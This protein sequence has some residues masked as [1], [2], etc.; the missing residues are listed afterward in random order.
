MVENCKNCKH[1]YYAYGCEPGCWYYDRGECSERN[2]NCF[3]PKVPLD[4]QPVVSLLADETEND[5][6]KE[7]SRLKKEVDYWKEACNK[8]QKKHEKE[9]AQLRAEN[10][11]L[12]QA[13]ED[14]FTYKTTQGG[15]MNVLNLV[16]KQAVEEFARKLKELLHYDYTMPSGI[17]DE[18]LVFEGID[19][20]LKEYGIENE[21]GVEI[22]N[23]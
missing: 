15:K 8:V 20:L 1:A 13:L 9:E 4:L 23:E 10:N 3:E 19:E 2:L 12:K 7:I 14:D 11:K 21:Y 16:R 6:I 5:E 22:E 18:R 17:T